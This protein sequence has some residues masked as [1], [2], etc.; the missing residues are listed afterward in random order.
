MEY[1]F[2]NVRVK[3]VQPKAKADSKLTV[4]VYFHNK[5]TEKY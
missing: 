3:Q 1:C 5:V 4:H 2:H